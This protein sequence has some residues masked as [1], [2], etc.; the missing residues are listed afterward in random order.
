MKNVIRKIWTESIL[1]KEAPNNE[2]LET[3]FEG[4]EIIEEKLLFRASRDGFADGDFHRMCDNKGPTLVLV[5]TTGG[6]YFGG[7]CAAD[8]DQTNNYKTSPGSFIFS[9]NKKTKHEIYRYPENA[10][11]SCQGY[12]PSFGGGHDFCIQ[13]NC[14]QNT[15]SYSTLGHT[16]KSPFEYNTAQ[17]RNYLAGG[18][19]FQVSDYEVFLVK[20]I[21]KP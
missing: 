18:Y 19:N 4:Q 5:K 6:Y 2:Y 13:S 14:H 11:Y 10:I 1:V 16:Y 12:G 17:A 7:F 21:K 8:W 3:M 9:L 20:L 15:T